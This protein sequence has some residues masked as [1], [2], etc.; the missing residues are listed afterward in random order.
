MHISESVV[1]D[2]PLNRVFPTVQFDLV[3]FEDEWE[4]TAPVLEVSALQEGGE[5]TSPASFD[6][7]D[8]AGLDRVVRELERTVEQL[9]AWRRYL[10]DARD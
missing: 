6:V 3:A 1:W 2:M 4:R 8:T 9:R 5:P 7:G 10:P